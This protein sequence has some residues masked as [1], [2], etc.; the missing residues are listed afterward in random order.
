MDIL[1]TKTD[2]GGTPS[3]SRN[4]VPKKQKRRVPKSAAVVLTCPKGK[5]V[6]TIVKIRNKI[7][8]AE[9]GIQ[10]RITTRVAAIGALI[11]EVPDEEDSSKTDALAACMRN[12]LNGRDSFRVDRLVK[13]A[14]L[15][16]RNLEWSIRPDEVKS[17]IAETAGC[18]VHKI[19][20]GEIRRSPMG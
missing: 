2:R 16:I 4:Q 7:I 11:I 5:Y 18:Q 9:V 1:V 17:A 14:E 10:N 12:V 6:D 8:L 20:N 19:G 15:R 13:T 3:S